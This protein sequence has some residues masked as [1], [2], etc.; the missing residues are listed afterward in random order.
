MNEPASCPEGYFCHDGSEGASCLPTCEG[1]SCPAGQR[2]VQLMGKPSTCMT[3]H[4]QDCE[5]N[6]CTDGLHCMRN[7]YPDAPGHIWME[8]LQA[9]GKSKPPCPEG[10]ACFLFRCR[11]S[12][13]PQDSSVCGPGLH[14]ESRIR[15]KRLS[16]VG[17]RP[18]SS[19][20][21]PCL[22]PAHFQRTPLRHAA[23]PW[24]HSPSAVLRDG[25]DGTLRKS[26]GMTAG[27]DRRIRGEPKADAWE[28][29]ALY[30]DGEQ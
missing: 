26:T 15:E 11:K 16:A 12:C 13:D 30:E 10:T 9:C 1:R 17:V 18:P 4:G 29:V 22:E 25:E 8:C 23:T 14:S 27:H 2:C 20:P 19:R 21:E 24:Q 5:L 7:A 3:V 6:P 28:R